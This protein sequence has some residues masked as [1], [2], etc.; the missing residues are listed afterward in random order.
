MTPAWFSLDDVAAKTHP[1]MGWRQVLRAFAD[2]KP[3][4]MHVVIKPG[5]E[6]E[7]QDI[8]GRWQIC[9]PILFPRVFQIAGNLPVAPDRPERTRA[10]FV[11]SEMLLADDINEPVSIM[12]P[13]TDLDRGWEI[14]TTDRLSPSAVRFTG[15]EVRQILDRL[16]G[17]VEHGPVPAKPRTHTLSRSESLAA[18][19][20]R[21]EDFAREAGEWLDRAMWPGTLAELRAFLVFLDPTLNT[22][23]TSTK[24]LSRELKNERVYL[25][26][27]SKTGQGR[28]FYKK[29]HPDYP[30]T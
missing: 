12:S 27:G 1:P 24:K 5:F 11:L 30:A 15:D 16:G 8:E 22:L 17:K 19:L 13:L 20:M 26:R 21:I 29:I 6:A 4:A 2:L 7:A 25:K 28:S 14:R 3:E 18:A 10:D 9:D 23:Q